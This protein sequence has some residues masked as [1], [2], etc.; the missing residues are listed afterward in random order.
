MPCRVQGKR[1]QRRE[2]NF[3]LRWFSLQGMA[4]SHMCFALLVCD[5]ETTACEAAARSLRK[6]IPPHPKPRWGQEMGCWSVWHSKEGRFPLLL[7]HWALEMSARRVGKM[8][9]VKDRPYP[10]LQTQR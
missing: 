7:M 1:A 9:E 8:R 5:R 10:S 2:L 6:T 3:V 4:S